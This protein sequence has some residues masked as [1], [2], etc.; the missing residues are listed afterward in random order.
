MF[1]ALALIAVLISWMS[2]SRVALYRSLIVFTSVEAFFALVEGSMGEGGAAII[3]LGLAVLGAWL[4]TINKP[5]PAPA[6]VTE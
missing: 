3:D 4:V 2:G 6:A 1:G 5:K